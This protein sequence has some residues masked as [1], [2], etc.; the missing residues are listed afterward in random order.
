MEFS[1]SSITPSTPKQSSIYSLLSP[2]KEK[3]KDS[4]DLH[5]PRA[6]A[7]L[8]PNSSFTMATSPHKMVV[9]P[10]TPP[11]LGP[12]T[13]KITAY[14][15]PVSPQFQDVKCK[16]PREESEG[17]QDPQ[18]FAGSDSGDN[19][20]PS[21]V[22]LFSH[23]TPRSDRMDVDLDQ[24]ASVI[25]QHMRRMSSQQ[26]TVSTIS[27]SMPSKADYELVAACFREMNRPLQMNVIKFVR[28]DPLGF[29]RRNKAEL[30]S[31]GKTPPKKKQS[32]KPSHRRV[33]SATPTFKKQRTAVLAPKP[34]PVRAAPRQPMVQ[35]FYAHGFQEIKHT[36]PQLPKAPRPISTREDT[37]YASIPDY[38]PS[39]SSLGNSPRSLKV[40][41][42]GS[43]LPLDNDPDRHLLH[44]VEVAA[45]SAL[46]LTCAQY[47]TSKRRIF[48]AKLDKL[49]TGKE[50]RKTDAQQACKID[51]NKASR[52]WAAF[53]RVHWF[54]REHFTRWL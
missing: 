10:S 16:L 36:S 5:S 51:V 13:P 8:T 3:R 30:A 31:I 41:W 43:P 54:D 40:E 35:T 4:F 25:S 19:G 46:R 32:S 37:D 53:D 22:P 6:M 7:V 28:E 39:L 9:A 45:A 20:L 33:L 27:S 21:D 14:L 29:L 42:K 38:A 34:R 52:L 49:R 2:P 12:T 47:L 1:W 50:F 44:D 18:L 26:S 11:Q 48:A 23:R 24:P 15:S 17:S